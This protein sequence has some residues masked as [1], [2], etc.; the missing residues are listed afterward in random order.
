MQATSTYCA[1]EGSTLI[2]SGS[3]EAVLRASK[4][5]VDGDK[6]ASLLVFDEST[7]RQ[8]DFDFRGSIAEIL[9]RELPGPEKRGPGRPKLGVVGGEVTLLPR[10]WE[11]LE[12]QPNGVSATLRRLVDEARKADSG[13]AAARQAVDAAYRFMSAMAG[14]LPGYEE[15]SRALYRRDRAAL[16]S[17]LSTWPADIGNKALELYEGATSSS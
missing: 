2:A 1:F 11:W 7:G 12:R 16:S 14:D 9:E 6:T 17:I 8:L 4:E 10:Q 3:L 13:E 5:L 15:A